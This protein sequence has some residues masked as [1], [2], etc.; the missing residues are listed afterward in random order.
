MSLIFTL[1]VG[2]IVGLI[3]W[4]TTIE[5]ENPNSVES[6]G[7]KEMFECRDCGKVYEKKKE[8]RWK[9][10]CEYCAHQLM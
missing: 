9:H 8:S 7:G 5:T 1:F 6:V 3:Y 2:L 4:L 10:M